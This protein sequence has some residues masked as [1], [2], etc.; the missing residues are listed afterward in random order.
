[1]LSSLA[2]GEQQTTGRLMVVCHSSRANGAHMSGF[3][4]SS[5]I[6]GEVIHAGLKH[7]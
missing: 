6:P 3:Q 1:M 4:P 7:T 5:V 2:K